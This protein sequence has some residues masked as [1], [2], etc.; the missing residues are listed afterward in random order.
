MSKD[1]VP[2]AHIVS[3]Q[4]TGSKQLYRALRGSYNK[5][6]DMRPCNPSEASLNRI[7]TS[8]G[9]FFHCWSHTGY[10]FGPS[11]AFPF[12]PQA[13]VYFRGQP[14]FHTRSETTSFDVVPR[15]DGSIG[16][17]PC[18]YR[19]NLTYQDVTRRVEMLENVKGSRGFLV[20]TQM[21]SLLED[22]SAVYDFVQLVTL[23]D[24]IDA[25]FDV[26]II[27]VP[28]DPIKWLCSNFVCDHSGVFVPGQQ[29]Q[30]AAISY[31]SEPLHIPRDYIDRLKLRL[32]SHMLLVG[33]AS[34]ALVIRTCDLS[35]NRTQMLLRQVFN[36]SKILVSY[37]QE[38]SRYD[39]P[40]M[41]GNYNE[42][43]EAFF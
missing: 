18:D 19:P 12:D 38:F 31:R 32:H 4:R 8:L 14:D 24:R 23:M 5:A 37:E 36:N 17:E 20:K 7:D 27:L 28:D 26:K 10:K 30:N 39:Y 9:E 21:A 25:L 16:Y 11:A 40:R 1:F 29:Q 2:N 33:K 3:L 15:L 34:D 6:V 43:V 35:T 41:I 22:L 42:V 13:E